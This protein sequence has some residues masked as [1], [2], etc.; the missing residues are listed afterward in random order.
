VP[1]ETQVMKIGELVPVG[2][3]TSAAMSPVRPVV[4]KAG[5]AHGTIALPYS[6]FWLDLGDPHIL[7][8]VFYRFQKKGLAF[9]W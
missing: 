3:I 5:R 7:S 4:D 1:F 9:F 6:A 8:P 2:I